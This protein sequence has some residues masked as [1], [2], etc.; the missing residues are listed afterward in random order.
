MRYDSNVLSTL[1]FICA[2]TSFIFYFLLETLQRF[3]KLVILSNLGKASHTHQYWQYQLVERFIYLHARN[4]LHASLFL[5][6]FQKYYKDLL[7]WVLWACLIM[8]TKNDGVCFKETLILIFMQKIKFMPYLFRAK[9]LR[10]CYLGYCR[11][12][13]PPTIK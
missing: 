12:A 11:H 2:K 6:I 8:A 1:I 3:C 4:E 7:L 10:L 9:I 13:W 5:E